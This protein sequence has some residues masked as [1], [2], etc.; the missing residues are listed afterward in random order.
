MHDNEVD[1]DQNSP[2]YRQVH[3][4]ML[5]VT[6]SKLVSLQLVIVLGAVVRVVGHRGHYLVDLSNVGENQY[7]AFTRCRKHNRQT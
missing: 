6:H 3:D 1:H 5:Q 7:G 2:T 4:N